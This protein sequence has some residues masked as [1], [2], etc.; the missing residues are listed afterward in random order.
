MRK[1]SL[2]NE[3]NAWSLRPAPRSSGGCEVHLDKYCLGNYGT[4]VDVLS[5]FMG[6]WSN[7]LSR[8]GGDGSWTQLKNTSSPLLQAMLQ[9]KIEQYEWEGIIQCVMSNALSLRRISIQDSGSNR[10]I[11]NSSSWHQA[12]RGG[13]GKD[14]GKSK[15]GQAMLGAL[16]CVIMAL[17]GWPNTKGDPPEA[18]RRVCQDIWDELQLSLNPPTQ[19]LN[20]KN[21][22][23]VG[24]FL[25]S[26]GTTESI[27][28][29][30]YNR[31]GIILSI[32]YGLRTCCHFNGH[33]TLTGIIDNASWN[34][35]H[36]GQCLL[37]DE[38]LNCEGGS[39]ENEGGYL[40]IWTRDMRRISKS[41][42]QKETGKLTLRD[43]DT[44][45][46]LKTVTT[47][48]EYKT[49]YEAPLRQWAAEALTSHPGQLSSPRGI[50]VATQAKRATKS[51]QKE[52][53]RASGAQWADTSRNRMANSAPQPRAPSDSGDTINSQETN[54]AGLPEGPVPQEEYGNSLASHGVTDHE[55]VQSGS[56]D[57]P[58]TQGE[59]DSAQTNQ[60]NR[61]PSGVAPEVIGAVG[62]GSILGGVLGG[63][64][65]MGSLYGIY[66]VYSRPRRSIRGSRTS[67][68]GGEANIAYQGAIGA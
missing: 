23:T 67:F 50:E 26:L 17:L 11:W 32:Y 39:G 21:M 54:D 1:L 5:G 24:E 43:P 49:S 52:T 34:L 41:K 22:K 3:R 65:A 31:L 28:K 19:R 51:P 13:T 27:Q 46:E 63:I 9:Q 38:R 29:D 35:S 2:K 25:G 37:K 4:R 60:V 8:D 66:R 30:N 48:G 68:K 12:L 36:L 44:E 58:T 33:Y 61:D 14:W 6:R 7:L 42:K 40:S 15:T 57:K 59:E 53:P 62:I 10:E 20:P 18:G 16:S 55:D 45:K 47:K 64:L 56:S